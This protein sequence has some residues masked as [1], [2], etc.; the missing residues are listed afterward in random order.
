[1]VSYNVLAQSYTKP[2]YFPWASSD[3]NLSGLLWFQ[4]PHGLFFV[5]VVLSWDHRW[6]LL[7]TELTQLDADIVC[8]QEVQTSHYESHYL[9]FAT[10][11][12][13]RALHVARRN[14]ADGCAILY[15]PSRFSA[16]IS[17]TC[18]FVVH[19]CYEPVLARFRWFVDVR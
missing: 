19:P 7:Q 18:L 2:G 6:G 10:S 16:M 12:E 17:A 11:L 9:P 4:P 15:R 14:K 5:P 13:Y 1:M 3:G 8:L